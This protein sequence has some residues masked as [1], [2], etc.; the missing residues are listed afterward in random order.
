MRRRLSSVPP[1]S[2]WQS[3]IDY[4]GFVNPYT[5]YVSIPYPGGEVTDPVNPAPGDPMSEENYNNL[6]NTAKQYL[7]YPYTWGGKTPPYFDCSGFVAY[8]YKVNNLMPENVVAYTGTIWT[9]CVEN[10]SQIS[11]EDARPGDIV[12][13][14]GRGGTMYEGNAHVGIYIGNNYIIDCSGGGVQYRL[15]TYHSRLR[16]FYRVDSWRDT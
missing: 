2:D 4:Y 6:I 5:G 1:Q 15:Y 8:C 13:Y 10:G 9:W 7:G 14:N 3:L 11:P 12:C 16:G